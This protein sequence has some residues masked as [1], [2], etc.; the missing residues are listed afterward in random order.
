[1]ETENQKRIVFSTKVALKLS[2]E[3]MDELRVKAFTESE[4]DTDV[5]KVNV[6]ERTFAGQDVRFVAF[7]DEIDN[8]GVRVSVS[9]S[10][11]K[12]PTAVIE[13]MVGHTIASA[14]KKA[15]DQVALRQ[16][17]DTA[18]GHFHTFAEFDP[19]GGTPTVFVGLPAE[20]AVVQKNF[21]MKAKSLG[22]MVKT[23]ASPKSRAEARRRK[24]KSAKNANKK[25]K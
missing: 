11:E 24:A 25:S 7:P 16:E 20:I 17:Y 10:A 22:Q 3:E 9:P 5:G 15:K 23:Y 14:A 8:S 2:S 21:Q 1:M 6:V 13:E 12:L 4:I 18:N 19:H